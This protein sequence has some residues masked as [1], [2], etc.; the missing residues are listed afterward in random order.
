MI[1]ENKHAK[2]SASGSHR[3]I[4]CPGSIKAEEGFPNTT[5]AYAE[6]GK[7]AH[8]LAE[9]IL[10]GGAFPKD[11]EIKPEMV[12]VI[13]KY[14]DYVTNLRTKIK[15]WLCED[16]LPQ[17]F[18][19]SKIDYSDMIHTEGFG[20]VDAIIDGT[21]GRAYGCFKNE[22]LHIIDL[23]YGMNKVTAFE[24]SQ[25]LLYALGAMST[26]KSGP[27]DG[28][29]I[30]LH[31]VQPRINHYDVW[32]IST[33]DLYKWGGY[34]R[35]KA[36]A[37][38]A[39]DAP[40]IPSEIA[41]KY[42][43]ANATCP[44][45]NKIATEVIDLSIKDKINV[46]ETK[47]ILDNAKLVINFLKKIEENVYGQLF[48]G[49]EFPGYKLVQGRAMRKLLPEKEELLIELLGEKA[50]NKSLVGIGQLEKMVDDETL[51]S[52]VYISTSSPILAKDND[53]REAIDLN[54]LKFE[55][56]VE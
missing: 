9:S 40:R 5:N 25:L 33:H 47:F 14:T 28:E 23:K 42:C 24:N 19:E 12:E 55:P 43:K 41:C 27:F 16:T 21:R 31:I 50:Y 45:L 11:L 26:L 22:N 36:E 3:W 15:K 49:Q 10:T 44:A 6:E 39:P 18:I 20:T 29:Y 54:E 35:A 7:L 13:T 30:S 8:Q 52:L 51:K 48:T 32:E 46:E 38:L 34:F 4:R 1:Q 2:L 37:A 53:K 17:L 56:V